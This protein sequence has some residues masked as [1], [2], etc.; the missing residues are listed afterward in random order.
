MTNDYQVI[1]YFQ[2]SFNSISK[3]TFWRAA[4]LTYINYSS[5]AAACVRRALKAGGD[6]LAEKRA[7]TSIKFQNW[8]GGKP[9]GDKK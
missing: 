8:Q 1:S 6:P 5:V 9:V 4:G 2:T 7:I 3:M